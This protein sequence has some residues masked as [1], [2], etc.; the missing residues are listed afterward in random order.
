MD[1]Y[2]KDFLNEERHSDGWGGTLLINASNASTLYH[3]SVKAIFM[4]DAI[5]I[6]RGFLSG[7]NNDDTVLMMM[8]ARL[9]AP[10]RQLTCS[11]RTPLGLRRGMAL[12][13]T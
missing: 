11:Q 3:R 12:S 8:H 1:P 13:F 5:S 7:V 6:I 10:V 9:R 2:G 4:D